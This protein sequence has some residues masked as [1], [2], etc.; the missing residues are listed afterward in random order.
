[1]TRL[2]L[3]VAALV[4]VVGCGGVEN[5]PNLAAAIEKTEAAGSS[6]FE[7]AATE[8]EDGR[9]IEIV[10]TGRPT[11]S[12]LASQMSCDYGR[13]GALEAIVVDEATYMRGEILGFA[14]AGTKWTK[15]AD[16]EAVR[17]AALAAT[18]PDDA[19][20]RQSGDQTR[21]RGGR[22]R[23]RDRSLPARHRL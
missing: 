12:A 4:V 3:A 19:P 14:G 10:C 22:P 2:L 7:V 23:R 18:A 13:D 15:F 17:V 20:C 9:T 1:M 21:R 8:T 6:L 16:A 11:T 5:E